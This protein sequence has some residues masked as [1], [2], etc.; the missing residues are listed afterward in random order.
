MFSSPAGVAVAGGAGGVTVYVADTGNQVIRMIQGGQVA[1]LAG[2]AGTAGAHDSSGPGVQ[3]A[4]FN[5]PSGLALDG[6]TVY[7]ADTGN[8]TLRVLQ[9]GQ[10]TTLAGTAG[11]PGSVDGTGPTQLNGPVAIALDRAG[12]LFVANAGSSTVCLVSPAQAGAVT[13]IIGNAT[14]SGNALPAPDPLPP[15]PATISPPG[16]LAVDLATGNIFITIDDA[17]VLADFQP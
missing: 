14:R 7:V 13:T 2:T 4:T 15:L 1:T 6:R 5:L 16:G 11:Q 3:D 17:V 8:H 9:G 10:V 12:N